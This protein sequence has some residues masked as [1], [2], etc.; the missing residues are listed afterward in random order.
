MMSIC[1]M[2]GL[3]CLVLPLFY[4]TV[5]ISLA[6]ALAYA[7]DRPA[8]E[9]LNKSYEL[10]RPHFWRLL[11]FWTVL[12]GGSFGA[13]MSLVLILELTRLLQFEAQSTWTA[14]N[15][16]AWLF[17]YLMMSSVAKVGGLAVLK[18]LTAPTEAQ[19]SGVGFNPVP[20]L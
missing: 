15:W 3:I 12:L 5:V 14:G 18:Q 10:T 2:A 11:V 13:E 1:C 16:L 20:T 17:P 7:E 9:A 19:E 6:P 4:A 8:E